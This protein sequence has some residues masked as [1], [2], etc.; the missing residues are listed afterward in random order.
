LFLT[1][2]E[3][4][5]RKKTAVL[6][7]NSLEELKSYQNILEN[8]AQFDFLTSTY[9]R[10]GFKKNFEKIVNPDSVSKI[11][12][13]FVLGDIDN[14]KK[15]NDTYGHAA[16]DSVLIE[17]AGLMRKA[18]NKNDIICRWGGEEFLITLINRSYDEAMAIAECIRKEI[19]GRVFNCDGSMELKVTMTFGISEY[20]FDESTDN[21]VSKA[22]RALYIG[23]EMGKNRVVGYESNMFP[24]NSDA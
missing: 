10:R 12:V 22:D 8:A 24:G 19:E 1:I 17:I 6:L 18:I 14:F 2:Y 4:E 16:G 13:S 7:Q 11:P 21:N 3:V 5:E 15:I 20:D 9:N 23:K